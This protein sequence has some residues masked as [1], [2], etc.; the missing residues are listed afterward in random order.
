MTVTYRFFE[1]G[2]YYTQENFADFLRALLTDGYIPNVGNG[3]AVSAASPASMNVNVGT[4]MAVVNGYIVENEGTSVTLPI[5]AASSQA[6]IDRVVVRLS[7]ITGRSIAFAVLKGT[8][9]SSPVPPTLTKTDDVYEMSLAQIRVNSGA[10]TITS[11][12]IM[13][14]RVTARNDA[15]G[16]TRASKS[17]YGAVKVGDGISVSNGVISVSYAPYPMLARLYTSD[18]SLGSLIIANAY[19]GTEGQ[20]PL[21]VELQNPTDTHTVS[22]STTISVHSGGS[23]YS[24]HTVLY[25]LNVV[26]GDTRDV[27]T[28]PTVTGGYHTQTGTVDIQLSELLKARAVSDSAGSVAEIIAHS[29]PDNNVYLGRPT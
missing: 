9:A 11:S 1:N 12:N 20:V 15:V 4:G 17:E 24:G 8:P 25:A 28:L 21:G 22:Y 23:V 5:S 13:D 16:I 26:T 27:K 29:S 10:T 18:Q 6:R 2:D 14:E 3:L 7:A 19:N